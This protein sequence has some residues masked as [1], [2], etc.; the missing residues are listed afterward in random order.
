MHSYIAATTHTTNNQECH[1]NAVGFCV[2]TKRSHVMSPVPMR[3]RFHRD[4]WLAVQKWRKGQVYYS[5]ALEIFKSPSR[6]WCCQ[7]STECWIVYNSLQLLYALHDCFI[8][9]NNKTPIHLGLSDA[10]RRQTMFAFASPVLVTI[11]LVW[12]VRDHRIYPFFS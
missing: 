2:F 12:C 6:L 4:S 1:S 5:L 7:R 8:S 9:P 3:C 10:A 11:L